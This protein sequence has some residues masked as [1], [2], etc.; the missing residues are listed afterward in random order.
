MIFHIE[1]GSGT[2]G[3]TGVRRLIGISA[4]VRHRAPRGFVLLLV[5][6]V[7]V[8]VFLLALVAIHSAQ[9]NRNT[10]RLQE[11]RDDLAAS[12]H[13]LQAL[14][15]S[16]DGLTSEGSL[17]LGE[18]E[19]SWSDVPFGESAYR[20]IE[21]DVEGQPRVVRMSCRKEYWERGALAQDLLFARDGAEKPWQLVAW[22]ISRQL[23]REQAS[24]PQKRQ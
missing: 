6:G 19:V 16:A 22:K 3:R 5:I 12:R 10:V 2:H 23:G 13:A 18:W 11:E 4:S 1:T 15:L 21:V 14:A 9:S 7:L 20:G 17:S 24:P 8:A